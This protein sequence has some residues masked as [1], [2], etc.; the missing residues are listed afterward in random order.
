MGRAAR[1]PRT[2]SPPHAASACRA[3]GATCR[4]GRG[5]SEPRS[6]PS[7]SGACPSRARG[8]AAR[9]ARRR[10]ASCSSLVR[11]VG[12]RDDEQAG[13]VAVEAVHDPG[14][15]L[16]AAGGVVL[17]QAV[18][19]RSRRVARRPDGRR[20]PPACRRPA[21]ARPP[22]RRAGP[23]TPPRAAARPAGSSTTTSSPPS[24]R[25]LLAA[26]LA[27]D[28][29]GAAGDQPLG[30][31]RAS[32]P[33]AGRRPRGRGARPQGR[34]SGEWPT[35]RGRCFARSAPARA[36]KRVATPTTMNTSARLNAGQ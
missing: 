2:A 4:C 26:G 6:G 13:G 15:V 23:S 30:E 3:S 28:E 21:G 17:D 10:I 9:R 33:P 32:P 31:R 14:P 34:E 11:L 1:G 16:V 24:S 20:C 29:D 8:S 25:W 18:H 27:V 5:R 35:R 22:R 12:A 7:A 19:E 36:P